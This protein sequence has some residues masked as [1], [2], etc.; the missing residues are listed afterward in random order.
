MKRHFRGV[1][2]VTASVTPTP[3]TKNFVDLKLSWHVRPQ[4]DAAHRSVRL[5]YARPK[6]T[7]LSL[8]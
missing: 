4:I 6:E 5:V 8:A 3:D 1:A 2:F 7:P